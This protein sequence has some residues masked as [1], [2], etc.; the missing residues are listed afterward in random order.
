MGSTINRNAEINLWFPFLRNPIKHPSLAKKNTLGLEK[1]PCITCD[2]QLSLALENLLEAQIT[3]A[4]QLYTHYL[5]HPQT[6]CE[7][8]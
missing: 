1:K 3:S 4:L 2:K 5:K 6:D 7:H 8:F